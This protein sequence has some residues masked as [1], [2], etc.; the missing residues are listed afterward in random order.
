MSD[1]HG[2]GITAESQDRVAYEDRN[3]DAEILG[4]K[5]PCLHEKMV[6]LKADLPVADDQID[7]VH[8]GLEDTGQKGGD[9]GTG[10][11]HSRGAEVTEDQDVVAQ[12]IDDQRAERDIEREPGLADASKDDGDNERKSQ[13]EKGQRRVSKIRHSQLD[14]LGLICV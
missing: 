6:D 10:N 3:A 5:S 13:E 8:G 4:Q 7:E 14:Q 2:D 11:A 12:K 9:R 1:D